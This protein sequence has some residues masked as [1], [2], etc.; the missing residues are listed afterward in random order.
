[1]KK[2]FILDHRYNRTQRHAIFIRNKILS[3]RRKAIQSL[4]IPIFINDH[5]APHHRVGRHKPQDPIDHRRSIRVRGGY[6]SGYL[7]RRQLGP[8]ASLGQDLKQA[9]LEGCLECHRQNWWGNQLRSVRVVLL[10]LA[11]V[12]V[13]GSHSW[14]FLRRGSHRRS[15]VMRRRSWGCSSNFFNGW[16]RR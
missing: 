1:M 5:R 7:S 13:G 2:D 3:H 8:I 11:V 12:G 9:K 14:A 16:C 4:L 10:F 15:S 6:L